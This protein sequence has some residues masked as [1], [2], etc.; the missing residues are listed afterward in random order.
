MMPNA[1]ACFVEVRLAGTFLGPAS[2]RSQ[3]SVQNSMADFRI[4]PALRIGDFSVPWFA[5][6]TSGLLTSRLGL[7]PAEEP[8]YE[9]QHDTQQNAG[10]YGEVEDGIPAA[11]FDIAWQPAQTNRQLITK[12][13]Q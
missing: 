10:D 7:S 6:A 2:W 9:R 1:H 5:Q 13:Y 3:S 11:D 8:H 4:S 12:R